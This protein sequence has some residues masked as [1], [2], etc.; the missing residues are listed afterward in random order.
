MHADGMLGC[1]AAAPQP[2]AQTCDRGTPCVHVVDACT[3]T[4]MRIDH[5]KP[6]LHMRACTRC[7]PLRTSCRK[8]NSEVSAASAAPARSAAPV[9]RCCVLNWSSRASTSPSDTASSARSNDSSAAVPPPALPRVAAAAA[10]GAVASWLPGLPLLLLGRPCAADV[11]LPPAAVNGARAPAPA[12]HIIGEGKQEVS[13]KCCSGDSNSSMH[14]EHACMRVCRWGV[15]GYR[16]TYA[17]L[18]IKG[19]ALVALCSSSISK[20]ITAMTPRKRS[21]VDSAASNAAASSCTWRC[22]GGVRPPTLPGSGERRART[23]SMLA[24]SACRLLRWLLASPSHKSLCR[25]PLPRPPALSAAAASA[26]T[27]WAPA[28]AP[29]AASSGRVLRAAPAGAG[30]VGDAGADDSRLGSGGSR[31]LSPDGS[32]LGGAGDGGAAAVAVAAATRDSTG[33]LAATAVSIVSVVVVA[34]APAVAAPIPVPAA[35]ADVERRAS[36]SL[37]S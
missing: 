20:R 25:P 34:W 27:P 28:S 31:E 12:Q 9:R 24:S 10:P 35:A 13:D 5:G 21:F 7:A 2:S 3:H 4:Y 36:S 15:G 23:S 18:C 1:R 8:F 22:R 37:R 26:A 14:G 19:H 32:V 29:C 17:T 33:E 6:D 30:T 16:C 11:A